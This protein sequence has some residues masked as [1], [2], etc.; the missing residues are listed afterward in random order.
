MARRREDDAEAL[1][2]DAVIEDP[3]LLL[4][5]PEEELWAFLERQIRK[6]PGS[7]GG[8]T[9]ALAKRSSDEATPEERAREVFAQAAEQ[10]IE[11]QVELAVKL[12]RSFRAAFVALQSDPPEPAALAEAARRL[13]KSWDEA[14]APV[15]DR[16]YL[17]GLE[18]S[19]TGEVEIKGPLTDEVEIAEA[20]AT[21]APLRLLFHRHARPAERGHHA[22][23]A[24]QADYRRNAWK[25]WPSCWRGH[26]AASRGLCSSARCAVGYRSAAGATRSTVATPAASAPYAPEADCPG[27]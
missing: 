21:D 8:L 9:P 26:S 23:L 6:L 3:L 2:L 27:C 5:A 1:T 18:D 22:W 4:N 7:E 15:T 25:V 11:R 20:V 24:L 10:R 12:V 19:P 13:Q 17:L 14:R 16:F